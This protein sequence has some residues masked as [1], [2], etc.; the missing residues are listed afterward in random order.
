MRNGIDRILINTTINK[1]N[2]R[3]FAASLSDLGSIIA[4]SYRRQ[5][6]TAKILV[7]DVNRAKMPNASG[8]YKRVIIGEA[9]KVI[10]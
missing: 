3:I 8:P 5:A 1:H 9:R 4:S 6:M 10:I 2:P 7:I